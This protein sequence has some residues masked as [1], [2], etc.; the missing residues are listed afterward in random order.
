M[1]VDQMR[2]FSGILSLAL[3][4]RGPEYRKRIEN[5]VNFWMKMKHLSFEESDP[6]RQYEVNNLLLDAWQ[7]VQDAEN[8]PDWVKRTP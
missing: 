3:R 5:R 6:K 1:N 7:C 4:K 8:D 2:L